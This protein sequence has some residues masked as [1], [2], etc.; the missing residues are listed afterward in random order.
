M[1]QHRNRHEFNHWPM[2]S[3]PRSC[4]RKAHGREDGGGNHQDEA[5]LW[6]VDAFVT[7]G[8]EFDEPIAEN[9]GAHGGAQGDETSRKTN[10][11]KHVRLQIVWRIGEDLER[12]DHRND[13]PRDEGSVDD[14]G[15][16]DRREDHQGERLQECCKEFSVADSSSEHD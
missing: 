1:E 8:H 12:N 3:I 10:V 9:S 15:E 6:L 16:D 14:G 4:Q 7:V 5:K 11:G 13:K 2:G